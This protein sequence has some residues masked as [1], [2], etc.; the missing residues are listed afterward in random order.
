MSREEKIKKLDEEINQVTVKLN[1]PNLC[2]GTL[3]VQTRVSGYFRSISNWNT[4][5]QQEYSERTE[6]KII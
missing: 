6:Y 5:K 4:G 3:D 2:K 1:D